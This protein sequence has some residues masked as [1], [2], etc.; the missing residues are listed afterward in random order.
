MLSPTFPCGCPHHPTPKNKQYA[1][2]W[3]RYAQGTRH[4]A[5][6]SGLFYVRASERTIDLMKRIAAKLHRRARL[7]ACTAVREAG[8]GDAGGPRPA[9]RLLAAKTRF[10]HRRREKAWDQSVWNEYIFFLSHGDYRSPQVGMGGW[11]GRL[12]A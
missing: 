11:R 8:A 9:S 4:M 5:F 2:G 10:R 7:G 12:L 3:S 1:Q 6:N